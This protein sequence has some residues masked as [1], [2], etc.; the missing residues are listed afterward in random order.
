MPRRLYRV[1]RGALALYLAAAWIWLV[2][3]KTVGD[4]NGPLYLV[5]SLAFWILSGAWLA[6]WLRLGRTSPWWAMLCGEVMGLTLLRHYHWMLW[7]KLPRAHGGRS[8]IRVLTANLLK[9]NNNLE[10]TRR[11]L[12]QHDVDVAVFQEVNASALTGLFHPL[13][14][15]YPYQYWMA[16]LG[17]QLGLGVMS[18]HPMVMEHR[19][20]LGIGGPFYLRL[21]VQVGSQSL[22][23][24]NVH[25]ISPLFGSPPVRLN[26]AL[27]IRDYQVQRLLADAQAQSDSVLLMG[28]WNATEGSDTYRQA[29]ALF[30]DCWATAGLGPGWTWPHNLEPYFPLKARPVLRLD[31]SFCSP[32]LEVLAAQ[33]LPVKGGSDHSPLLLTLRLP[34]QCDR[35][36]PS[37]VCPETGFLNSVPAQGYAPGQ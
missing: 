15:R 34:K 24:Y 20:S 37:R 9:K 29:S 32:D 18:R 2:L 1:Y 5:N 22:L 16:H 21:R 26:R 10:N 7:R 8:E 30:Q 28:D 14:E 11:R 19:H 35:Q 33:V 12:I 27:H 25:L 31:H 13:R 6:S 17:H 36:G 23:L 3:W 4:R